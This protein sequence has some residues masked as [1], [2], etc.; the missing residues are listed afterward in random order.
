MRTGSTRFDRHDVRLAERRWD[1]LYGWGPEL[2]RDYYP[3]SAAVRVLVAQGAD[4]VALWLNWA[5]VHTRIGHFPHYDPSDWDAADVATFFHEA[6]GYRLEGQAQARNEPPPRA[7]RAASVHDWP[8][9]RA[10]EHEEAALFQWMWDS[11]RPL[12]YRRR[13]RWTPNSTSTRTPI[14]L[15]D[16]CRHPCGLDQRRVSKGRRLPSATREAHAVG[17]FVV[18]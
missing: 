10:A 16:T 9:G 13:H 2:H 18:W 11:A 8:R 1:A 7:T 12:L 4:Y 14:T 15:L 3:T 17:R 6:T 5:D